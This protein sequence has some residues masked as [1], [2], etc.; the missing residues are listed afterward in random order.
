MNTQNV[1]VIVNCAVPG[2]TFRLAG[3]SRMA[4]SRRALL[5]SVPRIAGAADVD[6]LITQGMFCSA[7]AQ[8]VFRA[9]GNQT[10]DDYWIAVGICINE[11]DARIG[12]CFADAKSARRG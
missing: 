2:L 1:E 7:T 8:A 5:A 4:C 12:D 6:S 3:L 11:S 9:C 10:L